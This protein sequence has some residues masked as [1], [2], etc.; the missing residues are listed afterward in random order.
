MQS[1]VKS[2]EHRQISDEHELFR[3]EYPFFFD[4]QNLAE[5]AAMPYR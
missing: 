1:K 4:E 2:V 5:I 3:H